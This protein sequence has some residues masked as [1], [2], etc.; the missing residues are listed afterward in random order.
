M[1]ETSKDFQKLVALRRS[2]LNAYEDKAMRER[3]IYRIEEIEYAGFSD[4]QK[5]EFR[6]YKQQ[7]AE[8]VRLRIACPNMKIDP[9]K[10][11][12]AQKPPAGKPKILFGTMELAN[13]CATLSK[14]LR[15]MEVEAYAIDYSN[16]PFK[17]GADLL[18]GRF[19]GNYEETLK[20]IEFTAELIVEFDV[21][22]FFFCWTLLP[23]FADLPV[24][25]EMD[26]KTI[27]YYLG[28]EVRL[29]SVSSRRNPYLAL[30]EEAVYSNHMSQD[31]HNFVNLVTCSAYANAGSGYGEFTDLLKVYYPHYF[32]HYQPVRVEDFPE[33][34]SNESAEN[35][36]FLIVHA[37]SNGPIKGTQF[38]LDA[39]DELK[40]QY[41]FDFQ[42]IHRIPHA[43][44]MEI[45]KRAD[46]IIDQLILGFHGILAI[47]AM[48]LGKPV[49][50]YL[51]EAGQKFFHKD[52]PTINANPDNIR[53]VIEWALS[54]KEKIK[55][56]GR[57][58]PHHVKENHDAAKIAKF[59][60]EQYETVPLLKPIKTKYI[61]GNDTMSETEVTIAFE[62]FNKAG[63]SFTDYFSKNN[64]QNVLI[65]GDNEISQV[66]FEILTKYKQDMEVDYLDPAAMELYEDI[67]MV[68]VTHKTG[69]I[70]AV[71]TIS[72]AMPNT[73]VVSLMELL[74]LI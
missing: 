74:L 63:K 70:E 32:E 24:Y 9:E 64:Y 11:I 22:N 53:E 45:Y 67:D 10:Y 29:Y 13:Y 12:T 4:Q 73:Q 39:V 41:D 6:T 69:T 35:E 42:L 52:I 34:V 38:V 49:V 18:R 3:L 30:T 16:H 66:L 65:D 7:A 17:Y 33:V 58:G 8:Y 1:S 62:H 72:N 5:S 44:A 55:E 68:V 60:L 59:L 56:L 23:G 46:L 61:S 20:M 57:R 28:G 19:P 40:E 15:D 25:R 50:V 54:N 47:E 48:A 31:I 14:A 36:K 37:P 27:F 2:W 43:E 71:K 21:F 51:D 26:K